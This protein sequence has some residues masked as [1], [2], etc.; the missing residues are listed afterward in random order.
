M[1]S[2]YLNLTPSA[3]IYPSLMM[4]QGMLHR[5]AP[6][7]GVPRSGVWGAG[8]GGAQKQSQNH[9]QTR[10]AE[11]LG[12]LA[13][14]QMWPKAEHCNPCWQGQGEVAV[15]AVNQENPKAQGVE[16]GQCSANSCTAPVEDGK[17]IR[18]RLAGALLLSEINSP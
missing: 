6:V 7:Q 12:I 3:C 10:K 14:P 17:C 11:I 5:D 8:G 1:K 13:V 9:K 4:K 16:S 2:Q 15:Q 18:V